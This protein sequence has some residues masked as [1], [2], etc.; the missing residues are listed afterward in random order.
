MKK[1]TVLLILYTSLIYL[2]SS[3]TYN[4]SPGYIRI[5]G[6]STDDSNYTDIYNRT[7][8][9]KWQYN[10]STCL[11]MKS[12]GT[13]DTDCHNSTACCFYQ[14]TY[15]DKQ[16]VNCEKKKNNTDNY[17]A[18]LPDVV[19]YFGGNMILCDCNARMINKFVYIVFIIFVMIIA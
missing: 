9:I 6:L 1:H 5:R 3:Q 11:E 7:S 18:Y 8:T 13:I 17:C 10:A 14:Y 2:V 15:N 4:T 19:S 12:N 16:F